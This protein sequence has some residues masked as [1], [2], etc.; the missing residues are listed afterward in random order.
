[1]KYA[2]LRFFNGNKAEIQ[3]DY[4]VTN[5]IY[6]GSLH[7]DEVS[8]G[9]Y[10][11]ATIFLLEEAYNQYGAAT[12]V[13]P[14]ANVPGSRFKIEFV[15]DDMSS[16]D[17]NILSA[18]MAADGEIYVAKEDNVELTLE[19]NSVITS[20][21][22]GIHTVTGIASKEALQ[23]TIALHS[24]TDAGHFRYLKIYDIA[25][26]HL[27][28]NIYV[29]GETV[30]ED[31]RLDVLLSNLGASLSTK[32]QNLFKEHDIN[33]VGTDWKL[34][35][36][37]RKELLLE[38]SN[39]KPFIGTYKAIINAIK[40]FGYNN[41]TIK[42]YWLMIDDRSPMFGKMKAVE[43]PGSEKGFVSKIANNAKPSSSYK[44]TSR[45][46]L[47]YKLNT[48]TGT[49][50]QWDEPETKEVFDFTPDEVLIKLYGLKNKLQKEYLPLHARIIDIIGEGDFFSSYNTNFWNNQNPITEIVA[51][52]DASIK[53]KQ[54][55]LFIEDLTKVSDL[56]TG[57]AQDFSDLSIADK[58][59][60]Y[61]NVT[62]FYEDY[63]NSDRSTY[64]SDNTDVVIGS[65]IQL[66][67]TSF[68]ETWD[69]ATFTWNDAG[70][71]ITWLNWWKQNIYELKWY[72]TG[73]R[74]Y[75]Q[76]IIGD[77]DNYRKIVLA[78]PYSGT[79]SVV[80]E[81]ID[82]FNNVMT[83]RELD[84]IEVKM[85]SVEVYGVY[86]WK[87]QNTYNWG[88]SNFKWSNAGGDWDFPQQNED[89][90]DEEIASLYLSL[91]RANYL[92]DDSK[93]VDF[94]MVRRYK[95]LSQPSGYAET[96]GPYFWRNLNQ[97]TW[98][99]GKHTWW[100]STRVGS[101]LAASFRITTADIGSTLE[102]THIDYTTNTTST[103]LFDILIDLNDPNS[104][105]RWIDVADALNISTDPIISKFN[106]NVLLEDTNN[107]GTE[108]VCVGILAVGKN[109]SRTNDFETVA[110]INGGGTIIGENKYMAYNPTYNDVRIAG[111]HVDIELL[112]HMTFSADKSRMPG[113]LSYN[114]KLKNNSR[115]DDDIYYNNKWLTY[116]FSKKGDY[117][118]ELEVQDVNGNTNTVTKNALTIKS[119]AGDS[120]P[121]TGPKITSN[122]NLIASSS[123]GSSSSSPILNL[124]T[125]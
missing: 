96:S 40:F 93:G 82:L 44:K 41:I 121:G 55:N 17:I 95:D 110:I 84:S 28:A 119:F 104:L 16:T 73:P 32:D 30:G 59:T 10:E 25:D 33:E 63:Y 45:F 99:D 123:P 80:F 31:E 13:K 21:V 79:Y 101:D 115:D 47:Y 112:T 27:V 74:N 24:E 53:V 102:I 61:N 118:I 72:I 3:L 2:G 114:W 14:I 48:P 70:V 19:A 113:K 20:T 76:T 100:D 52:I 18:T 98:N 26:N 111:D 106:Y 64:S 46:G 51:G 4:D 81:Q 49:F 92:H 42:E 87:D 120:G 12:M 1:M 108:D 11:T 35:N 97:H 38:L 75:S 122:T 56:F 39:I 77:V 9:L 107:D 88:K 125:I 23:F 90:V 91:D 78:L 85:K 109:Y 29:Y 69:Q 105:Q 62:S 57:P 54:D 7:L 94:S 58:E 22:D 103:G 116:L 117:T 6:T 50:D 60:L 43:V 124:R 34:M 66:D 71:Y 5:E 86:R 65:P 37:K 83:V 67:C 36:R 68:L 89:T 8:T 15:K